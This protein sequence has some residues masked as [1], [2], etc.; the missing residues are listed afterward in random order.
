MWKLL[1]HLFITLVVTNLAQTQQLR[2][3]LPLDDNFCGI[4]SAS[5]EPIQGENFSKRTQ[6]P[7]I[8]A[9]VQYMET[10]DDSYE[11]DYVTGFS[12]SGSLISNKHV[13]TSTNLYI[14]HRRGYEGSF[15]D[16]KTIYVYPDITNVE[17][18]HDSGA[19]NVGVANV[20]IYPFDKKLKVINNVFIL[21]LDR[22]IV[23]SQY[24]RPVCLWPFEST[25]DQIAGREA[26]AVGIEGEG[27]FT[28]REKEVLNRTHVSV[29]IQQSCDGHYEEQ[30]QFQNI[31]RMFCVKGNDVRERCYDASELYM[32]IGA[33]WFLK[34]FYS[35]AQRCNASFP[36]LFD[37]IEQKIPFI[38]MAI[39][40]E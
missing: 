40:Q 14:N 35:R 32:K 20:S 3:P 11:M 23:F 16:T 27:R 31:T 1:V 10:H 39:A 22:E 24:I 33:N 36:I 13:I 18:L 15:V 12:G 26:Y 9:I 30:L 6:F 2:Q 28:N 34:G 4:M 25:L 7:W 38:R 19:I 8:V 21:T 29:T 17:N 37:D 5:A